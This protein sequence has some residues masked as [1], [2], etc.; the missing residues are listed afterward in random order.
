MLC[1][2]MG[3]VCQLSYRGD[4]G[5][6]SKA[7]FLS[8]VVSLLAAGGACHAQT[9]PEALSTEAG[10]TR[11]RLG[12]WLEN[13]YVHHGYAMHE[14]MLVTGLPKERLETRIRAAEWHRGAAT[15]KT[16]DGKFKVLP[17]PGGRHP[18]IGFL[19]GAIDPQRG[20]KASIFLPWED[21]GYAV[22]DLP[23]AIFSN[24]GLIFL[25]HT[26]VP[27]IWEAKD[28]VIPNVDW[29]ITDGGALRMARTLPNGIRFGAR[30]VGE[31]DHVA[32]RL[33]IENGTAETLTK[34]R[35]QV[36][37]MLKGAPGFNAQDGAGRTLDKP[38]AVIKA[39]GRNRWILI[40]FT[41]C[42]RAW[43]NVRCPCIH[44]DPVFPDAAPGERVSV[45]GRVWCYEG[46]NI[47]AE[48]ERAKK[49][50]AR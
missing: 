15:A 30:M 38:V 12:F 8:M 5:M 46:D 16:P 31:K 27:T 48:I 28:T 24:L 22:L 29:E 34:L 2:V 44:A 26:H 33:W 40:A 21:A 7:S 25:A 47:D 35:T 11:A 14:M 13:M 1:Q 3:L 41:H 32:L 37:L 50:F 49:E 19:E 39:E 42:G 4:F 43:G 18:R 6:A 45:R 20:T 10:Q 17:Y 36:C 23:E 9:A